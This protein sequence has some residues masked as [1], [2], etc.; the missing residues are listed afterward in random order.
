M[1]NYFLVYGFLS[2]LYTYE[3]LIY[4]TSFFFIFSLFFSEK[5]QKNVV[6]MLRDCT[7]SLCLFFVCLACI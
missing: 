6:F 1:E 3:R 4:Q 2:L 7:I 5:G